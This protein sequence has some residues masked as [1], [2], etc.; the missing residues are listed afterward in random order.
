MSF[1]TSDIANSI[2]LGGL[3]AMKNNLGK[4]VAHAEASGRD[5][6]ELFEARLAPDMYTAAQQVWAATDTVR[7]GVDRLAGLE[8]TSVADDET[9]FAELIGRTESTIGHLRNADKAALDASE[10]RELTVDLGVEL[11][12]TGRTF[13]LGFMVPNFLFHTA[14]LYDIL[15]H[16]GVDLGKRDFMAPHIAPAVPSQ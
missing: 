11:T 14:T 5:P 6:R 3:A 13:L 12:F 15:R 4:A 9:T 8:P 2:L 16:E 10:T 7:R 1:S